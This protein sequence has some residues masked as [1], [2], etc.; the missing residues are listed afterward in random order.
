M[1]GDRPGAEPVSPVA[2]P[3]P[4]GPLPLH[5]VRA[6]RPRQWAKNLLVFVAPAAAGVLDHSGDFFRTLAAFGIFCAAASGVYL[7]N[8]VADI[9]ADRRHPDKRH[10]P[11]A[12]GALSVRTALVAASLL[13]AVAVGTGW[14]LQGWRMALVVGLYVGVS[15]S[16][17]AW[18]KREPVVELI[19]VASGFVFR[20]IAGGVATHVP[21]SN[22]FLAVT[23]FG[24]LFVVT[25]KRA[26][27]HQRLGEDRAWHRAV[28]AHYT[29]GFLRSTLT[30]TATV[31]VTAYCLWAF[32][33]TGLES[34]AGHHL[35][36]IQ[37]TVIPVVI[38]VLY[39]FRLIEAGEGGAPEEL[40]FKD[41]KLQVLGLL[42]VVLFAVGLYG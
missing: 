12:T 38:G 22:W 16:Y 34:H 17:T 32:E 27:E 5:L 40:V 14:A 10:R 30:L 8:D 1:I 42:W 19:A 20:A 41:T 25:G 3:P 37:L 6:L 31:T 9:A 39:V 29:L 15:L 11:L 35:V 4:A 21:L 2:L 23:S 28:L 36:W 33:H 7:V 18:L 13:V 24:A 26:A